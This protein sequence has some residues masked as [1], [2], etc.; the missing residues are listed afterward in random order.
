MF[1]ATLFCLR[2]NHGEAAILFYRRMCVCQSVSLYASVCTKPQ[3]IL[4]THWRNLVRIC[5][6]APYK[7]LLKSNRAKSS[8]LWKFTYCTHCRTASCSAV[9]KAKMSRRCSAQIA[10]YNLW[11]WNTVICCE[12]QRNMANIDFQY[13]VSELCARRSDQIFIHSFILLYFRLTPI[14]ITSKTVKIKDGQTTTD[15]KYIHRPTA[16]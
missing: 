10:C 11:L 7:L 6:N 5:N 2:G 14:H 8:W 1:S 3:K 9:Q 12:E 16:T 15:R 4:I 13:L